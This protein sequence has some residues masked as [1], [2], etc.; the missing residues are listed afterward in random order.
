MAA[1]SPPPAPPALPPAAAP[2]AEAEPT[3]TPEMTPAIPQ[4]G[5]F[6]KKEFLWIGE[7]GGSQGGG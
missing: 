4:V 5:R 3:I 7:D 1:S 2:V 6:V